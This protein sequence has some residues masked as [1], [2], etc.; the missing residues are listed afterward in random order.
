MFMGSKDEFE[1]SGCRGSYGVTDVTWPNLTATP[2]LT[3]LKSLF[4]HNC[5]IQKN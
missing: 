2:E 1:A 5:N 4:I 3:T